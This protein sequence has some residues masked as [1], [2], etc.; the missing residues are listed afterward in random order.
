MP[1]E[2]EAKMKVDDIEV[3]A[4]R[5][6]ARGAKE[7]GDFFEVNTF[8]DTEDRRLLAADQGLR[9]RVSRNVVTGE[10]VCVL[11]HK[12]PGQHGP[13][14]RR[15]ETEMR[16]ADALEARAFIERL[17]FARTISFEKK[18]HS[19]ELA[20]CKV[21]LDDVPLL[22]KFVEIEG[23][24]EASVM[25]VRQ[26]LELTERPLIKAGYI[27]MLSSYLQERGDHRAEV[28]F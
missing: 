8:Y 12:G 7:M 6:R 23:P 22:G 11:T 28:K 26:T 20:D 18:R 2:I 5:L 10:S 17:G 4:K 21:E 14:K 24:S 15:E 1:V 25:K 13:L 3:I 27:A 9:V 19:W 16:V